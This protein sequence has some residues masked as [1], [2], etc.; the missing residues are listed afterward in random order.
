MAKKKAKAAKAK[1]APSCT[2]GCCSPKT[3]SALLLLCSALLYALGIYTLVTGV[4]IQIGGKYVLGWAYIQY[5]LAMIALM[6]A[7]GCKQKG[8]KAM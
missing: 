4:L 2:S 5:F 7:K 3:G 1:S 6:I 8:W